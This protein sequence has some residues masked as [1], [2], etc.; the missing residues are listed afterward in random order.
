MSEVVAPKATPRVAPSVAPLEYERRVADAASIGA[1]EPNRATF[2]LE[3]LAAAEPDRPEA[4][5]TMAAISSS[6]ARFLPGVQMFNSAIRKGG[7]ATF[8]IM[9]D[10]SR[11]NFDT[12]PKATCMGELRIQPTEVSFEGADGH[13]FAASWAELSEAGSN[14]FFGSGIGGFHVRLTADGK[15]RNFNLA[16]RS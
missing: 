16:P 2:R 10:H 7:K 14:R 4:Y 5:Q 6:A 15:S 3:H 8:A 12:G 9:H 1:E 11:G 13:R